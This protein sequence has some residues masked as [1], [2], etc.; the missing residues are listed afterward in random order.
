MIQRFIPFYEM[1]RWRAEYSWAHL[2]LYYHSFIHSVLAEPTRQIRNRTKIIKP[3]DSA[4]RP[5]FYNTNK[6]Y[7]ED[8]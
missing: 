6:A 7:V 2:R 3:L 8:V 1:K 5:F 4:Y